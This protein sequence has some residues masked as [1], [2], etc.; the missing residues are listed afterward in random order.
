MKKFEYKTIS[1]RNEIQKIRDSKNP[2]KN[3][4]DEVLMLEI[5]N[6]HGAKGWRVTNP[7]N[8]LEI[9]LEREND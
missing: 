9:Y 8:S 4:G 6:T 1:L 3:E 2:R 7:G 5:L